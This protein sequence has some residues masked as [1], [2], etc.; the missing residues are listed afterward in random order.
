MILD[1]S[2]S[3]SGQVHK[4][5][6]DI[7]P[8]ALNLLNYGENDVIHLV[9]FETYVNSYDMTIVQLKSNS[10][11]EGHGG[12]CMAGVYQQVRN[13]LD[14]NKDKNNY[15]ISFIRRNNTRSRSNKKKSRTT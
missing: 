14:N 7:I 12:T 8:R 5:I 2:G 3:M 6:S 1:V 11:I 13:I 4:L 15:N 10:S 9:T